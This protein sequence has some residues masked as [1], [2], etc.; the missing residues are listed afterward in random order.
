MMSLRRGDERGHADRGWLESWHS[1]SFSDYYDPQRMGYGAL[2]VI[3]QDIIV[4]TAGF[5]PHSHSDMEIITYVLEGSIRHRDS[6]G[7]SGDLRPGE[8]QLMHAGRGISHSEINPSTAERTH[9]LQIWIQPEGRGHAPGYEQQALD[10]EALRRGFTTVVGPVGSG[11]P[12]QIH[13]DARLDI[14]WPRAGQEM[15]KAL[16]AQRRYYLQVAR[17]VVVVSGEQLLG[18]DALV[19]EGETGLQVRAESDAELLLF[20]LA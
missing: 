20:D 14:A 18:G 1:F 19:L 9:L 7:G 6:T 12:F 15:Q 11:T 2:R 4:P 5:P 13:Q 17:G 8:L 16:S 10:A 3:N